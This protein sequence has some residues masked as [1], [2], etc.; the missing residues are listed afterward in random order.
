VA[1]VLELRGAAR[2]YDSAGYRVEALRPLDLVVGAGD[3]LAVMGPSGSGK[4]TLLNLMG[5]LTR[6]SVGQVLVNGRD[7]T[8][9]DDTAVSGIR[10]AALGF[11]FQAFHL[12]P[13]L[14]A[15]E[16][17][18]LP[19]VYGRVARAARRA[20]AIAAP[21]RVRLESRAYSLPGELSGGERQRV[22]IARAVARRPLVLLCDE[23]TGN[24][25]SA[26]SG[27]ITG[28]IR[29]LNDDGVA[30]VVV[31]HDREV[32]GHARRLLRIEDGRALE[33]RRRDGV[34]P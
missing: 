2:V 13:R 30:V 8:G 23:P 17:V 14:T 33:D 11:V 26:A 18:E 29:E 3:Y 6:P 25:D 22:A 9:L 12:L 7:T 24:L 15:L 32:A 4:S 5:L 19:L 28:L 34:Q 10:G 16:N 31:T 20:A 27:L 1:A 21:G